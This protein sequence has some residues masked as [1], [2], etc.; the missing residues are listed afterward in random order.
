MLKA[1]AKTGLEWKD[2]VDFGATDFSIKGATAIDAKTA[3]DLLERGVPFVDVHYFWHEQRIPGAK[4]LAMWAFE[5]NEVTLPKIAEK[6]QEVVIYTSIANDS[7]LLPQAVALAV[8]WGYEKIYFFQD[9][10]NAW[11]SAGYPIETDQK[12]Y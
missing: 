7:K 5:F 4:H 12:K 3:K 9:G 2:L 11:K 8:S 1:G 10:L 6:T